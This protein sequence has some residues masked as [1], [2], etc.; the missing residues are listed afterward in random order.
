MTTSW[1]WLQWALLSATFAAL[2][3][4]FGKLGVQDIPADVATLVRAFII[5][6]MLVVLVTVTGQW[7]NPLSLRTRTW[8]YLALSAFATGASWLCYFRALQLGAVSKVAPVDKLSVVL[9]AI[10][11]T[12]FLAE[13]PSPRDWLGIGSIGLGVVLLALKR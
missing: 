3:A 7:T 4:I 5:L 8:F 6:L 10:F 11:A 12:I 2:T 13:R 1:T 9:V